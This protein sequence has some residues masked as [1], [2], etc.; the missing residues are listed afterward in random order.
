MTPSSRKRG[1]R[2]FESGR[3]S[4][5]DVQWPT[6]R[7]VVYGTQPYHVGLDQNDEYDRG[8]CTCKAFR[9]RGPCKHMWALALAADAQES[10][11]GVAAPAVDVE[12]KVQSYMRQLE[13]LLPRY[14]LSDNVDD[15]DDDDLVE[16]EEDDDVGDVAA[17]PVSDPSD[18]EARL[19]VME[20]VTDATMPEVW[21]RA[22]LESKRV[23]YV[24]HLSQST[25][26]GLP[27]IESYIRTR[28]KNGEF[29]VRKE[30]KLGSGE[31]IGQLGAEDRKILALLKPHAA[32]E[33]YEP[34]G[35]G[36]YR[37]YDTG[38]THEALLPP[39]AAVELLELMASTGRLLVHADEL[40]DGPT[41]LTW[42]SGEPWRFR[43]TLEP[44]KVGRKHVAT[45]SGD[46]VRGDE[47]MELDV[48]HV[49]FGLG[50]VVHGTTVA[51]FDPRGAMQWVV[52]LRRNGAL[53]VP[54]AQAKRLGENLAIT[55]FEAWERKDEA[56]VESGS[57]GSS[58]SSGEP[59]DAPSEAVTPSVA[60]EIGADPLQY[61]DS[62]PCTLQIIYQADGLEGA[63]RVDPTNH[64]GIVPTPTGDGWIKRDRDFEVAAVSQLHR[65]GTMLPGVVQ[66]D[67]HAQV[68]IRQVPKV[69]EKAL[70]AGWEVKAE[71]KLYR[72]DGVFSASVSSGVDWFDLDAGLG[73]GEEVAP[74]PAILEAARNGR[75]FVKLG[76]GSFGVL[77]ENWLK[78]WGLLELAGKA[79]GKGLRFQAN[80]GWILDALL[81]GREGVNRDAGFTGYRERLDQF[82]GVK[83]VKERRSFQGELRP[84]Q[85]LAV[86][87]FRFLRDLGLGGCLADDMGLGKTVQVLALLEERRFEQKKLD[88]GPRPTLVVA[89][90]SLV[91]NWIAEAE[92][93]APKLRVLD[94][95][96]TGRAA[97]AGDLGDMGRW[98]LVVT[99]YG[100]LRRDAIK[101]ADVEFDYV[102]LD[103][104]TAI[105]NASSQA[106]K[107]ARLMN[108]RHRLALSGTPIENHL[109]ELWSLFEFL[110]PGMLGAST[111]FQR[112]AKAG[113]SPEDL[114]ALSRSLA[115]FFLRRTKGEVLKDL[116]EK[117]EQVILCELGKTERKRYDEVRSHFRAE[118]L[119][120]GESTDDIPGDQKM[121]VLEAL[122]RLR[123]CACHPAL[124]DESLMG[125]SSAKLDELLPRLA[126]LAE[127]GHKVLV[128]SQF[129]SFLKVLRSRLDGLGL[130][131]EYL[132]GQTRNRKDKVE[133]FQSDDACKLFLISIKAGGHGLNLTAAD[134][135]FIM[136]PWWNPAVEA[137][138]V[139]RAHRMGQVKPVF[140]YR[141]IAKDTVEEKVLELQASKRELAAAVI[142]EGAGVLRSMTRTDLEQLLS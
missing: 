127:K 12:D 39:H 48:P 57:S 76:D 128:F 92:R 49:L 17:L 93:F 137:Q 54:K 90:N 55:G 69:V 99:T 110:N 116:P 45:L 32:V 52:D 43:L 86:G 124:M 138:A 77:P 91:F 58:G 79:K 60:L 33:Q 80:Q 16:F 112:F 78:S 6:A 70:Q 122:L 140:A 106:A 20:R 40:P 5:V 102:V 141:L 131:Y 2:Y 13:R 123:Q 27:V 62:L 74:L 53:V 38:D 117:T 94:Y 108:G 37:T 24:W 68:P 56:A 81:A 35:Y 83:P 142:G 8:H 63:V 9:D 3:A 65:M 89:P 4:Q 47:T 126:E 134:Y 120:T 87:W 15:Y 121:Q 119:G 109:G 11:Q 133:R 7:G 66:A 85:R 29:G 139:D 115:P 100:T 18:W 26:M 125:E 101:L 31:L 113:R 118:L 67:W 132:D 64:A 25:S 136:D 23:E 51:R 114:D 19:R 28:K 22:L 14:G 135:V 21:H 50:L 71:G 98:D 34:Y 10:Q 59:E 129:T 111:A 96:G 46:L 130:V 82:A 42:D 72:T 88:G 104:A 61:R 84:Y 105:K 30:V 97:R 1:Q 36:G 41:T 73:F 44:G 103:E 95:T 75:R 107:A